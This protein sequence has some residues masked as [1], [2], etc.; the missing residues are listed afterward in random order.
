M[1]WEW[2][3]TPQLF[4]V[5]GTSCVSFP[6]TCGRRGASKSDSSQF[7]TGFG[8]I[9]PRRYPDYAERAHAVLSREGGSTS[10]GPGVLFRETV[11]R[12]GPDAD[13]GTQ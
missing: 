1:R 6:H 4:G 10:L 3:S 8:W 5:V 9:E 7:S 11:T 12:V 2:G 13:W